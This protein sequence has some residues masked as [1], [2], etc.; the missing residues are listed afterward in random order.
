MLNPRPLEDV[1]RVLIPNRAND[2]VQVAFTINITE[3]DSFA[4]WTFNLKARPLVRS[5]LFPNVEP[6]PRWVA[7]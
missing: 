1:T 2:N 6:V 3:L 4:A 7:E 5:L